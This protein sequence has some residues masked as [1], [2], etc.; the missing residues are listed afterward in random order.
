MW[1]LAAITGDCINVFFVKENVWPF[2]QDKV[3]VG[4]RWPQGRVP[5]SFNVFFLSFFFFKKTCGCNNKVY[6]QDGR[7]TEF[8]CDLIFSPQILTQGS[9]KVPGFFETMFVIIRKEGG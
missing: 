1:P 5:L 8:H 9:N 4:P 6:Y 7:K 3:T 2:F